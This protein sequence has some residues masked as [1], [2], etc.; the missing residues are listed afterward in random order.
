MPAIGAT[1]HG[2]EAWPI[3]AAA[4]G[5]RL[6]AGRQRRHRR[7]HHGAAGW[8]SGSA[9]PVVIENKPGAST[10]ISIQAV[11]NAPPDGNTLLFIAASAALNVSLFD[12]LPFNL[13]RDIVPVA[14]HHRFSAGAA[15]EPVAAGEDRPRADRLRQGQ[16]GQ[17]Q[18][19]LVRHRHDLPCGRRAVQDDG[20]HRD[21]PRAVSRRRADDDGPDRRPGAGRDRRADRRAAAYQ[22]RRRSA[23]SRWPAPTRYA[24]LPDVP[25]I[26][27][28][29]PLFVA[30]SWC[31]VGVPRGTPPEIVARLN[32]EINA[33]LARSGGARPGSTTLATTPMFFTPDGVRR[34]HR[35]RDREVAK[36]GPRRQ[37]QGAIR[38]RGGIAQRPGLFNRI[39]NGPSREDS[40]EAHPP[41]FHAACRRRGA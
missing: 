29:M 10:N 20:R 1:A 37:H 22:V 12:N 18:H 8:R 33:G 31:G 41:P 28:T 16:S 4:L 14:G 34:L 17:D 11:V 13:Q 26:G 6:P 23:R 2:A 40:H 9:R 32:R 27:E 19:R 24:G 5:G 7:A 21:D 3:A 35:L 36:G 15:G 39:R 25:T 30:N 38:H